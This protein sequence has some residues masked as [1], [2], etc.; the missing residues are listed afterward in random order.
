MCVSAKHGK[1]EQLVRSLWGFL[2][3]FS[4]FFYFLFFE[5]WLPDILESL[6]E[7]VFTLVQLLRINPEEGVSR[8]F[9]TFYAN[10]FFFDFY[11]LYIYEKCI[12]GAKKLAH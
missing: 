6:C 2:G 5:F 11:Q 9:G 4:R 8:K 3:F 1:G 12:Y 7:L 10:L